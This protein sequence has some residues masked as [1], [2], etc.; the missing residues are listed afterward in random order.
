LGGILGEKKMF[1]KIKIV[2]DG[3]EVEVQNS[4][5]YTLEELEKLYYSV[6]DLVCWDRKIDR[7]EKDGN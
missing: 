5:V 4:E 6:K 3:K 1:V 2:Y 7:G